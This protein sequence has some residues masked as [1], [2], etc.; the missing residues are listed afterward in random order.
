[1]AAGA[2]PGAPRGRRRLL[3]GAALPAGLSHLAPNPISDDRYLLVRAWL[4]SEDGEPRI[5]EWVNATS[6]EISTTQRRLVRKQMTILGVERLVPAFEGLTEE[7]Q[8][9]ADENW[10]ESGFAGL[11]EALLHAAPG[12][13]GAVDRFLRASEYLTA[14]G[15]QVAYAE[16]GADNVVAVQ[17]RGVYE[18]VVRW[19]DRDDPNAQRPASTIVN[20]AGVRR[21]SSKARTGRSSPRPFLGMLDDRTHRGLAQRACSTSARTGCSTATEQ[22]TVLRSCASGTG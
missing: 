16:W 2:Q 18:P 11:R 19:E 1:M 20:P 10:H 8:R 17:I 7:Q 5:T 12:T 3:H 4:K 21:S 14:Y 15:T 13:D 6:A 22:P 9:I